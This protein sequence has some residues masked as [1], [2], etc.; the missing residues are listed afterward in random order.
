[1]KRRGKK[2]ALELSMGTI[3]I[4]VL[5]MAMLILGLILVRNIFFAA[6]SSVDSLSDKV[7]GEITDLFANENKYIIIKLGEDRTAKIKQDTDGFG[8]AFGA[9]TPDGGTVDLNSFKYKLNLDTDATNN[10]VEK[11]GIRE[12]EGFFTQRMG[13]LS[14]FDIAEGDIAFEIVEVSIPDG[15]PLCSQ[16]VHVDTYDN[17]EFTGYREVFIIQVIRRGLL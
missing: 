10:C 7:K 14:T 2:A 15:T 9:R 4:L 11:V 12:V 5:A 17:G 1:M 3:V 8:I 13:S 16:K 6:T